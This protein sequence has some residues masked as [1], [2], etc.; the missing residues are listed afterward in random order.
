MIPHAINDEVSHEFGQA[1]WLTLNL[2]LL[3]L[4]EPYLGHWERVKVRLL[5]EV[6]HIMNMAVS[7]L[8]Q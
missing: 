8:V 7:F 5:I 4:G 2:V 6:R 3:L 1:Y